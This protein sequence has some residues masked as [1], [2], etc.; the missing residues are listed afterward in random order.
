MWGFDDKFLWLRMTMHGLDEYMDKLGRILNNPPELK[1]KNLTSGAYGSNT[2]NVISMPG[3]E[4]FDLIVAL[5]R[6]HK[7]LFECCLSYWIH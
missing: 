4:T 5:R 1:E 2:F 6:E 3:R 7:L